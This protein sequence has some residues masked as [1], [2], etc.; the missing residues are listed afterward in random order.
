MGYHLVM[1]QSCIEMGEPILLLGIYA[2][3]QVPEP[4]KGP[5]APRMYVYLSEDNNPEVI[6]VQDFMLDRRLVYFA[7]CGLARLEQA[8]TDGALPSAS[9]TGNKML[10]LLCCCSIRSIL[11]PRCS[12]PGLILWSVCLG[13][14][15][16]QPS[17]V[18]GAGTCAISL[19]LPLSPISRRHCSG[20]WARKMSDAPA[21]RRARQ[22]GWSLPLAG[23]TQIETLILLPVRRP[24]LKGQADLYGAEKSISCLLKG[25]TDDD[26]DANERLVT[27]LSTDVAA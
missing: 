1:C 13:I 15:C 25:A 22:R 9:Q 12:G 3:V 19:L 6:T 14:P 16:Q 26:V 27:T 23:A 4:H 24:A 10:E 5:P 18:D 17:V 21:H 8:R 11:H 7:A 2:Q 20:R